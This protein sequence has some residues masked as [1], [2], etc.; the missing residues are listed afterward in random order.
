MPDSI[1]LSSH[2]DVSEP[3]SPDT[4]AAAI[5]DIHVRSV[6][7]YLRRQNLEAERQSLQQRTIACD[8]ELLQLDGELRAVTALQQKAGVS[9][10]Q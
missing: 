9:F 8:Q 3:V 6:A 7:A 10:G 5:Q 2:R 1:F 4:F